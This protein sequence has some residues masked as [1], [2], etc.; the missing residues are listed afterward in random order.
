LVVGGEVIEFEGAVGERLGLVEGEERDTGRGR[1]VW[2]KGR[3]SR[4]VRRAVGRGRD[5]TSA[6]GLRWIWKWRA[7][8]GEGEEFLKPEPEPA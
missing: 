8:E 4:R 1:G 3:E 7:T 5:F 2:E 6:D